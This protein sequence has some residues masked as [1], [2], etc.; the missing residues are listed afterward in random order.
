MAEVHIQVRDQEINNPAKIHP[1][2]GS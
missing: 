1:N 2:T